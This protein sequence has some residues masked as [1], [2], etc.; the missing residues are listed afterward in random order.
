MT[1]NQAKEEL[2]LDIDISEHQENIVLALTGY[3][4]AYPNNKVSSDTLKIYAKALCFLS[5]TELHTAMI[6]ILQNSKLFPTISEILTEVE[7]IENHIKGVSVPTAGEAW[8]EVMANANK[9]HIYERWYYSSPLIKRAAEYFGTKE[10][11][12]LPEKDVSIARAQFMR[13]YENLLSREK[14]YKKYANTLSCLPKNIVSE[15]KKIVENK[16]IPS[17]SRIS[18]K[19][20]SVIP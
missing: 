3:L 20:L 5:L 4:D 17:F 10:L 13:I 15:L 12:T 11:C 14:Q 19:N 2:F 18:S 16:S 1:S 9:Y 6:S 7:N 8:Q